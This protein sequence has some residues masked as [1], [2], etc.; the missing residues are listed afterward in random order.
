M[1]QEARLRRSTLQ[2]SPLVAGP[3]AILSTQ[4]VRGA[5][6][7]VMQRCPWG[8]SLALPGTWSVTAIT[9]THTSQHRAP[10]DCV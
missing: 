4:D 8:S 9:D 7:K 3:F 5:R 2:G 10:S 1:P 6:L